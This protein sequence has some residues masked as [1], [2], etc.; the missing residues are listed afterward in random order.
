MRLIRRF[1]GLPASL[2]ATVFLLAGC[3]G[4]HLG[5]SNGDVAGAHSIQI[6]PF[7]N[8]TPQPR[9]G[10]YVMSSLRKTLQQDATYRLNTRGEGDIILSG[11]LLSYTRSE[12]SF[13]PTDVIT[14][15]N[16]QITLTAQ[17]TARERSTGRVILDK[18]VR[19]VASLQAGP[20]LTS[21]ERQVI[22]LLADDLARKAT[23]L[24]VD[25]SW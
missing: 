21:A 22:P 8:K 16:Y 9:L 25:G 12:I 6:N 19:G 4:Y 24:L 11:T 14:L 13:V 10:D 23:A 5:P 17:I 18:P 20:D 3:A 15:Q 2:C 1:P 7:V